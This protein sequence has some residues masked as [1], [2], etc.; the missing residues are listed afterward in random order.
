MDDFERNE[1]IAEII[2]LC[3]QHKGRAIQSCHQIATFTLSKEMK[4]LEK[5]IEE[6]VKECEEL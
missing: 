6:L 3:E 1:K 5:R 2:E 4:D